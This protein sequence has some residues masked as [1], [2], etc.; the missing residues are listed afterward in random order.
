MLGLAVRSLLARIV[1]PLIAI[2]RIVLPLIAICCAGTLSQT[3]RAQRIGQS[4]RVDDTQCC[5]AGAE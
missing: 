1:L 4:L 3:K 5:V 2:S